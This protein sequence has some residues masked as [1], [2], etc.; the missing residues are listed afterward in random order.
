[1]ESKTLEEILQIAKGKG[2][3]KSAFKL[4][5]RILFLKQYLP[6][7]SHIEDEKDFE[8]LNEIKKYLEKN[9]YLSKSAVK[10]NELL[11]TKNSLVCSLDRYVCDERFFIGLNAKIDGLAEQNNIIEKD[12]E[13]RKNIFKLKDR[14]LSIRQYLPPKEHIKDENDFENL[15]EIKK[16]L[17]SSRC[18]SN[19]TLKDHELMNA[20]NDLIY[21][22]NLY[23]HNEKYYV[24]IKKLKKIIIRTLAVFPLAVMILS[25]VPEK[26]KIPEMK[27]IEQIIIENYSGKVPFFMF[28]EIEESNE[29]Y[30]NS[31]KKFENF[32]KILYDN[33][34]SPVSTKEYFENK[35]KTCRK[36]CILTFDGNYKEQLDVLKVIKDFSEKHKDFGKYVVLSIIN[37]DHSFGQ[38]GEKLKEIY[39]ELR[40]EDWIE[41]AIHTH[42]HPHMSK[43]PTK[44]CTKQIDM[45][46]NELEVLLEEGIKKVDILTIPYCDMPSKETMDAIKNYTYNSKYGP[47]K[48]NHV[49]GETGIEYYSQSRQFDN[50]NIKRICIK[51][52]TSI[53]KIMAELQ[54]N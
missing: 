45:C 2:N 30:S 37:P 39:R 5:E 32:L 20:K 43:I 51:K 7:N 31:I 13:K 14:I 52:N 9:K 54:E 11:K 44:K 53:E 26:I 29:E 41:F 6:P 42:D 18:L 24:K 35:F 49:F 25:V 38:S 40:E 50:W 28:H 3:R 36:P 8:N 48:I 23:I 15:N 33:G 22:L 19:S 21:S 47:V 27:K 17:E 46:Y 16:Y 1:M 34:Y 4:K 10:D 12:K